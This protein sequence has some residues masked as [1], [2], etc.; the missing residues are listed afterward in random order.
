VALG[1]EQ[2]GD[3]QPGIDGFSAAKFGGVK[4]GRYGNLGAILALT[5]DKAASGRT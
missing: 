1:P 3:D 5:N 4:L 2:I